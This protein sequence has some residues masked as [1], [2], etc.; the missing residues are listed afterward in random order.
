MNYL[1]TRSFYVTLSEFNL[2]NILV[3]SHTHIDLDLML[4]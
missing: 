1:N 2:S 4:S 3:D